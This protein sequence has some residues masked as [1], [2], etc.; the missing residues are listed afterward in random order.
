VT[1]E[2]LILLAPGKPLQTGL[3][4]RR[5][6][7]CLCHVWRVCTAQRG[8]KGRAS[9][10]EAQSSISGIIREACR[11]CWTLFLL[12][13]QQDPV[14]GSESNGSKCEDQ[15]SLDAGHACRL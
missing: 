6:G 3:L 2:V 9:R 1:V 14:W 11:A 15:E 13:L 5:S 4:L 8:N 10:F 12:S 7:D